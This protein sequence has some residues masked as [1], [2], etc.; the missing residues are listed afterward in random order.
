MAPERLQDQLSYPPRLMSVERAAHYVGFG[1]TKFR[2]LIA[3]GKMPAAIDVDGSPRWDRIDLD[4][5]VDDLKDCRR[6]PIGAVVIDL[7]NG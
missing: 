4:S 6:D 2:E 1:V 7:R 5:A 3:A